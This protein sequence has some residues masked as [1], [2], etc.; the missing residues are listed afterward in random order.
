MR[1]ISMLTM[2]GTVTLFAGCE[3]ASLQPDVDAQLAK[4]GNGV[5]AS[6]TGSGIRAGSIRHFQFNAVA[7]ADGSVRGQFNLTFEGSGNFSAHGEVL[8]LRVDGNRAWV[9]HRITR[10]SDPAYEGTEGGF[11]VMDDGEGSGSD[12]QLSLTYVGGDPGLAQAVCD[13]ATPIEFGATGIDG[14][15]I[16]VR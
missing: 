15:N 11:Y 1:F 9:G 8:C 12:D 16:Q 7:K 6:A 4:G 2:A 14:G 5:V 10:S 3:S 13:G